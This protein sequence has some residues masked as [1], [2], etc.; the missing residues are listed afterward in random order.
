MSAELGAQDKERKNVTMNRLTLVLLVTLVFNISAGVREFC[1][2]Y[3]M[4]FVIAD[5]AV[6][7]IK[8]LQAK[9]PS[10]FAGS[11]AEVVSMNQC[12]DYILLR[13]MWD[14]KYPK[15][16][17][18]FLRSY[19]YLVNQIDIVNTA[20]TS[21]C[22]TEYDTI[23]VFPNCIEA[24]PDDTF[25]P[26]KSIHSL[27]KMDHGMGWFYDLNPL[28]F[29][30]SDYLNEPQKGKMNLLLQ[31]MQIYSGDWKDTRIWL[32]SL[33][34]DFKGDFNRKNDRL[35]FPQFLGCDNM[36]TRFFIIVMNDSKKTRMEISGEISKF[37][38][39]TKKN[40]SM[41]KAG[42]CSKK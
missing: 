33:P 1:Y 24:K 11:A 2:L 38:G 5:S 8:Q 7:K 26:M 34:A 40:M 41:S 42:N 21:S 28:Y 35:V 22:Q 18:D 19:E 12:R 36:G 27:F 17:S 9:K 37:Y 14:L 29:T 6:A 13:F 3:K 39:L 32:W 30:D 4:R 25:L 31:E 20:I 10:V 23:S 16:K 15:W